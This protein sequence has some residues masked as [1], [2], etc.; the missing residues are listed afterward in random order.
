MVTLK[1]V[2][3]EIKKGEFVCILGDVGSG[4]SSIISM[5]IGDLLYMEKDFYKVFKDMDINDYLQERI[6]HISKENLTPQRCP[7]IYC[8][9]DEEE[10]LLAKKKHQFVSTG[11]ASYAPQQPWIQNKTI[12]DNIIFGLPYEKEWYDRVIE[13]CQLVR[14]F[15]CFPGGD[16]TELGERG[17]NLSGGQKARISLARA[18]YADREVIIMDDPVSALDKNVLKSIFEDLLLKELAGKTRVLVS[19]CVDYLPIFDKI[20]LL[21]K[22]RIIQVGKYQDLKKN[23]FMRRLMKIHRQNKERESQMSMEL[24][25]IADG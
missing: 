18:V 17:V 13:K 1:G 15:E 7:I 21:K 14:D 6:R 19:H 25:P 9:Q 4:K 20:I 12:R 23:F 16:M 8:P 22:G 2:N 24:L 10:L 3:L 11:Q 5:M